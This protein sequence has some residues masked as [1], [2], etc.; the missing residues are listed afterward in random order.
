MYDRYHWFGHH[1]PLR[2]N[3]WTLHQE[4]VAPCATQTDNR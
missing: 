4:P 1:S 2:T 3:H